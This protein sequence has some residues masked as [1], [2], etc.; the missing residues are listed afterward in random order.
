MVETTVVS[1]LHVDDAPEYHFTVKV[2]VP[3][4]QEADNPID[5]PLSIVGAGG[6]IAPAVRAEFTVTLSV[7]EV[8]LAGEDAESVTLTQ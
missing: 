1:E 7:A 2:E 3:P 4:D 6:V 5:C 8:A